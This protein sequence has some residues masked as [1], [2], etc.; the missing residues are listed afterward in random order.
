M[1]SQ[2]SEL[3]L[4]ITRTQ[5]AILS[6]IR[7]W[8]HEVT[9]SSRHSHSCLTGNRAT[10]LPPHW[11]VNSQPQKPREIMKR[12]S[13]QNSSSVTWSRVVAVSHSN[14]FV[15]LTW[16]TDRTCHRIRKKKEERHR[17]CRCP[18][19]G[20]IY[21]LWIRRR[22]PTHGAKL[23]SFLSAGVS[24]IPSVKER[25]K[26]E[27]GMNISPPN[28]SRDLCAPPC[29]SHHPFGTLEEAD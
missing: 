5:N 13:N 27:E 25:T 24:L 17:V 10:S 14:S 1:Q 21:V 16:I 2:P 28:T 19:N 22:A 7:Q 12:P 15:R 18:V 6:F 9:R 29:G 26:E 23:C 3:L 20:R 4:W 11:C 8:P